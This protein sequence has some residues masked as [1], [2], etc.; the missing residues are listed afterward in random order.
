MF[1]VGLSPSRPLL[2]LSLWA[3]R[4]SRTCY[5]NG[6]MGSN[7]CGRRLEGCP[8]MAAFLAGWRRVARQ[9]WLP[10]RTVPVALTGAAQLRADWISSCYYICMKCTQPSVMILH[11]NYSWVISNV[12]SNKIWSKPAQ[13]FN[14]ALSLKTYFKNEVRVLTQL[15][16][17]RLAFSNFEKFSL[18][19]VSIN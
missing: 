9:V 5:L 16:L 8:N 6:W 11:L 1:Y 13:Y 19:R 10:I 2:Y 12:T 18:P 7:P 15:G 4:T 14:Y 3:C 17:Q